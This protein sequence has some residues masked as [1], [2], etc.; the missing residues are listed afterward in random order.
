MNQALMKVFVPQLEED[1]LNENSKLS[2]WSDFYEIETG[3]IKDQ[4]NLIGKIPKHIFGNI[5]PQI[6]CVVEIPIKF[7][8]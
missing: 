8:K 7:S 4:L 5:L 2:L 6:T 3:V 1:E